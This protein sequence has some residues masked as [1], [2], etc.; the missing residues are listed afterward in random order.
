MRFRAWSL[1]VFAA[2]SGSKSS[3]PDADLDPCPNQRGAYSV[4]ISGQGCGDLNASAPQCVTQN[5]CTISFTSTVPAGAAALNGSAMLA[6]DG[7]FTGAAI[8]E[9]TGG[10]SG[11]VGMWN[12]S[13]STLTVDCGGVGTTQSCRA[14]L[15]RTSSTCR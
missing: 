8:M 7:S 12:A 4:V 10:R 6:A 9:G 14:T 5:V 11:C 1:V 3:T 15:A 13:T 2:C